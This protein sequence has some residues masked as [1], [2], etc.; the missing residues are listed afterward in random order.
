M[1]LYSD[2]TPQAHWF[3]VEAQD[4]ALS[5]RRAGTGVAR[6]DTAQGSVRSAGR[7]HKS[8]NRSPQRQAKARSRLRRAEVPAFIGTSCERTFP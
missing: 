6:A 2:G 5:A 7:L 1:Y 3:S 4:T 8:C